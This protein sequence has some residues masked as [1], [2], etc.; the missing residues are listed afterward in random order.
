MHL[1]L[2]YS[3]AF[4][5]SWNMSP[6]QF[7]KPKVSAGNDLCAETKTLKE[8]KGTDRYVIVAS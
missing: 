7:K 1:I 3:I 2:N 5:R 4:R 8:H 6:V